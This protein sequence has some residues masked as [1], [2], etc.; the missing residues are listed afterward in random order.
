MGAAKV[1]NVREGRSRDWNGYR[2][3]RPCPART[4]CVGF[5]RFGEVMARRVETHGLSERADRF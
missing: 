2:G 1:R 4:C 3:C 5:I